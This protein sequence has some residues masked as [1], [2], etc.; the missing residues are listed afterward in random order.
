MYKPQ[1]RGECK[2]NAFYSYTQYPH[3]GFSYS[4]EKRPLPTQKAL[5]ELR[6]AMTRR[7]L[8]MLFQK[9]DTIKLFLIKKCL[10]NLHR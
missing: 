1:Q 9:T 10:K 4:T 2:V 5:F 8:D 6:E 7:L 3:I